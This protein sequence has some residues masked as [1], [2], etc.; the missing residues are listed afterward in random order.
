MNPSTKG[1]MIV[2]DD[3]SKRTPPQ[4]MAIVLEVEESGGRKADVGLDGL[5]GCRGPNDEEVTP[6]RG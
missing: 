2:A 5:H 6:K 1:T 4:V 3:Q